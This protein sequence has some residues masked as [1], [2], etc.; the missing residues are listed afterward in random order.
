MKRILFLTLLTCSMGYNMIGQ[1]LGGNPRNQRVLNQTSSIP[2]STPTPPDVNLLSQER[3]DMYQE[4]L[5]ID[6]FQKEV[7]KTFLKDYYGKTSDIA[8]DTNLKY[9][10]KQKRIGD[11]KKLLEKTLGDIF[12]EDQVKAIMTE[13][14]FGSKSKELKKEK[15]KEKKRRKKDKG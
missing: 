4:I 10:E 11:E 3:A 5:K 15:K 7:L 12:S 2:A 14:Q 1:A 8:F 13:E 6:D 9:D